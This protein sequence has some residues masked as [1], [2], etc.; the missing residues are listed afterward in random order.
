LDLS[1]E[2][3]LDEKATRVAE[4]MDAERAEKERLLA[5]DRR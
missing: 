5:V 2:M 4:A 3:T 1:G